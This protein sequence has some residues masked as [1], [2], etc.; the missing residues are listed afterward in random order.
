MVWLE[1]RGGWCWRKFVRV[2]RKDGGVRR[3]FAPTPTHEPAVK[4][5]VS[6]HPARQEA[7]RSSTRGDRG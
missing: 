1:K 7:A 2:W 6:S 4:S 3:F 5:K